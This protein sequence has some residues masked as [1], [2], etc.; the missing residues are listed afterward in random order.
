MQL[1]DLM[2][3]MVLESVRQPLAYK[4]LPLPVR[5]YNQVLV[6]VIACG[7]CRTDLHIID[8]ELSSPRLPLIPGHEIVGT[9]VQT[10]TEAKT[11]NEGV[12]VGI[13]WLSYTCGH[14]RYCLK[15]QENLCNEAL[16][17]GYNM[18]GGYAEYIVI[19]HR[20]CIL[21][22]P[23]Y[24]N[25]QGA[26]LLCAGLIGYRAYSMIGEQ[27]KYIGIYGFGAAAH[28]IIQVANADGKKIFAF[29]R[30][31]DVA[32]QQFAM[33]LGAQW[34]GDSEQPSPEP[35]DAAIIFAPAGEL[36]PK[37]LLD[38]DKGGIVICGGIHMSDI[39][40]FPYKSLWQERVIRSV[41]NLTRKDGL[42][43]YKRI[44]TVHIHTA[45]HLYPLT[46]ANNAL[47]DLRAGK[48]QGAA[49]LVM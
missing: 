22:P 17:T 24:A 6:K 15:G 5:R 31:G 16:F 12:V 14:C 7:V 41:A 32:T 11:L 38:T 27:A 8:G 25:A 34:A 33:K 19:D 21:L 4:T 48:L 29:T 46:A 3:A 28:I 35:L 23:Q 42:D 26:P 47:D 43:F 45:T 44:A 36:V 13:P 20:Y 10:G 30:A 18:D 39:P 9:V 40:G 37:A 2:H 49:V 1:P